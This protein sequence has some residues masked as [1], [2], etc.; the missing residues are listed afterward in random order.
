MELLAIVMSEMI[1]SLIW[2]IVWLTLGYCMIYKIPQIVGFK[3]KPAT[4]VKLVGII[5][6][7]ISIFSILELIL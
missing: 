2:R 4:I 1:K 6:C 7:V 3:K 5:I